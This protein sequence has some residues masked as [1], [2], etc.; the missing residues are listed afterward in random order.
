[1][2]YNEHSTFFSRGSFSAAPL[3]PYVASH[4]TYG[5]RHRHF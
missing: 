3:F 4:Q 5:L 1:M 2:L